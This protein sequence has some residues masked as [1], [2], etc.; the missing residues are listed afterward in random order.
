MRKWDGAVVFLQ[1]YQNLLCGNRVVDAE[2]QTVDVA[3][4]HVSELAL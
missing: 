4:L 1:M 2:N 3:V